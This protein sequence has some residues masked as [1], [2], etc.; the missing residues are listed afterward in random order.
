MEYCLLWWN[1]QYNS[2]KRL[3]LVL[4]PLDNKGLYTLSLAIVVEVF[5]VV[6]VIQSLGKMKRHHYMVSVTFGHQCCL[7]L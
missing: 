1:S 2:T 5:F 7:A 4:L 3:L 6:E